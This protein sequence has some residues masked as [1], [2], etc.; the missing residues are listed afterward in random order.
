MV[1]SGLG[2]LF[3]R[4]PLG[5]FE[6]GTERLIPEYR[7]NAEISLIGPVVMQ[8]VVAAEFVH[9]RRW[10]GFPVV[11]GM[12]NEHIAHVAQQDAGRDAT[13]C[14]RASVSNG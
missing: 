3:G 10:L 12:M 7:R 4:R 6:R 13:G 5:E 8:G 1:A 9:R 2:N 14:D 11:V